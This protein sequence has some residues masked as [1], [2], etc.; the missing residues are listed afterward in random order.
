MTKTGRSQHHHKPSTCHKLMAWW[1]AEETVLSGASVYE[2]FRLE[3]GGRVG[4]DI[5]EK[6]LHHSQQRGTVRWMIWQK[7]PFTPKHFSI[8]N[9]SSPCVHR[10]KALLGFMHTIG[11]S[12]C[13]PSSVSALTFLASCVHVYMLLLI[14][15]GLSSF[16]MFSLDLSHLLLLSTDQPAASTGIDGMAYLQNMSTFGK[17]EI[18]YSYCCFIFFGHAL[19]SSTEVF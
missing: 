2:T 11:L 9:E 19:T 8:S 1:R 10:T 14:N 15:L 13:K 4:G 3:C 16:A 6:V 12:P 18:T 5:A 7:C 17:L